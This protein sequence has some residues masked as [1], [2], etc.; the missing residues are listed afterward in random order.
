MTLGYF[1]AGS[2]STISFR[3]RKFESIESDEVNEDETLARLL[4]H[5]GDHVAKT[6]KRA[7]S[8]RSQSADEADPS[9]Q[10]AEVNPLRKRSRTSH[11]FRSDSI[12]STYE[13]M[14]EFYDSLVE[15][16]NSESEDDLDL[17]SED[18][19]SDRSGSRRKKQPKSV[20][21]PNACNIHKKKHQK[22][23]VDCPLRC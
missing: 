14:D 3:K 12:Y 23:P 16:K 8:S 13:R 11:H 6:S 7:T 22:C 21:S 2:D 5:L 19:G 15:G 18:S 17:D 1:P 10:A 20:R 9:E 4:F